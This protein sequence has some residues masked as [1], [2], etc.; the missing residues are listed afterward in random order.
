MG[1]Y[2]AWL[3]SLLP[4]AGAHRVHVNEPCTACGGDK[5]V[6]RVAIHKVE[7][8]SPGALYLCEACTEGIKTMV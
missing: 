6:S 8:P 7:G 5:E 1:W 4:K 2:M 3:K